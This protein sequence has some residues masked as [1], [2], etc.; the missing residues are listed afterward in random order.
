[1]MMTILVYVFKE[2]EELPADST[3]LYDTFF[4]CALCHFYQKLKNVKRFISLQDMPEECE[5]YL[6][7]LSKF[8]FLTIEKHQMVFTEEDVNSLC[9]NSPLIT[10]ELDGLGLVKTRQLVF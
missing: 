8:T 7:S 5:R 6:R 1:M 4:A 2:K 10:S 9:P 3:N